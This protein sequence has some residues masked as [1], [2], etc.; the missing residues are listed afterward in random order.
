MLSLIVSSNLAMAIPLN[1]LMRQGLH[2]VMAK[3]NA[4]P[5]GLVRL[6]SS[7]QKD[8]DSNTDNSTIP[9]LHDSW[10]VLQDK[11]RALFQ[12]LG[13]MVYRMEDCG[14]GCG[15]LLYNGKCNCGFDD[16]EDKKKAIS[17]RISS[18]IHY[19]V[20]WDG[21]DGEWKPR[22]LGQYEASQANQLGFEICDLEA[23]LKTTNDVDEKAHIT[24]AIE[25]LTRSKLHWEK[26]HT[27]LQEADNKACKNK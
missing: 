16:F 4:I 5:S 25:R 11:K 1:G 23:Q 24:S 6:Y 8:K 20:I 13:W 19:M 22:N 12:E 3:N 15:P 7:K 26:L 2:S 27:A 17:V 10:Y 18:L 14:N 21:L 9:T